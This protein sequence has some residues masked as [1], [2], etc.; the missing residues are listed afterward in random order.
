M[1]PALLLL[2]LLLPALLAG[3]SD[4]DTGDE[5]T[6][7]TSIYPL[8]YVAERVAGENASV[9][10]LTSPGQEPQVDA[11]THGQGRAEAGVAQV[12]RPG[13]CCQRAGQLST[14]SIR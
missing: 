14:R 13:A 1:R 6:V 12:Y 3:C 10:T 2:P 8:E 7:V 11:M 4:D 9:T 5:L